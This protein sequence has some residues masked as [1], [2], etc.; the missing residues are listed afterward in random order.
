MP[1]E[2]L[3]VSDQHFLG[4][5][6]A[7]KRCQG[8]FLACPSGP[9]VLDHGLCLASYTASLMSGRLD[10]TLQPTCLGHASFMRLLHYAGAK[11]S[12]GGCSLGA[13]SRVGPAILYSPS[14]RAAHMDR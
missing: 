3:A 13:S 7:V 1:L 12:E 8:L 9:M 4:P 11:K 5:W 14:Y 6:S 10:W 2:M